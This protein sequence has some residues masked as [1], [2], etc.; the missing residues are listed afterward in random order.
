MPSLQIRELP[1]SIYRKLRDQ[2][3]KEFRSLSQ[4]AIVTLSRGLEVPG[5]NRARRRQV[6]A[7]ISENPVVPEGLDLPDP[8]RLVREDRER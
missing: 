8:V 2:A 3:G 7:R 5:D 4:Q 1:E 6:M